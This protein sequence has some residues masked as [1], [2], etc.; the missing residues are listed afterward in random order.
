[1][2]SNENL[3]PMMANQDNFRSPFSIFPMISHFISKPYCMEK[4]KL[5]HSI[6]AHQNPCCCT[7]YTQDYYIIDKQVSAVVKGQGTNSVWQQ[8]NMCV[9]DQGEGQ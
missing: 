6:I 3:W 8:G 4:P 1:M 2:I 7:P 5:L 9:W